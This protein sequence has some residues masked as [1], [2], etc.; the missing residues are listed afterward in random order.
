MVHFNWLRST[1]SSPAAP[2][3]RQA[4][5]SFLQ[6]LRMVPCLCLHLYL[7]LSGQGFLTPSPGLL[8]VPIQCSGTSNQEEWVTFGPQPSLHLLGHSAR[9]YSIQP[10]RCPREVKCQP[11]AGVALSS[12]SCLHFHL[13]LPGLWDRLL[14]N[15]S[16]GSAFV[17][18]IAHRAM[19][20]MVSMGREA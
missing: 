18:D 2:H 1:L 13:P 16:Q 15:L 9:T 8:W 7:S 12:P 11:P 5:T 10:L 6:V 3:S 17:P 20:T 4:A 14:R 19:Y